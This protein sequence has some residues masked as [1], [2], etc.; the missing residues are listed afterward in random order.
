M[1]SADDLDV[2]EREV[3]DLSQLTQEPNISSTQGVED[4]D[5]SKNSEL[6]YEQTLHDLEDMFEGMPQDINSAV[7]LNNLVNKK[8]KVH[9]IVLF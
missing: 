3:A 2:F 4:L 9:V 5:S 1:D 6:F 8:N 7:M